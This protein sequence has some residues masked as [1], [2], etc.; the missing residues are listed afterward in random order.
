[1]K[2][3]IFVAEIFFRFMEGPESNVSQMTG[4]SSRKQVMT[5]SYQNISY[6]L[7]PTKILFCKVPCLR[8]FQNI[9][10]YTYTATLS[11]KLNIFMRRFN[12]NLILENVN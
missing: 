2:S 6:G 10:P 9:L 11:H 4:F 8:P 5:R 3:E 7:G 1:M 12:Y